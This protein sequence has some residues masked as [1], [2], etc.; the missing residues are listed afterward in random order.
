MTYISLDTPRAT[1]LFWTGFAELA[2]NVE[3]A[4]RLLLANRREYAALL[5]LSDREL[6][7]IGMTRNDAISLLH[8]PHNAESF[9]TLRSE[10]SRNW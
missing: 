7:D 3:R 1:G 10:R 8:A 5:R 4:L 6:K 9:G 2:G